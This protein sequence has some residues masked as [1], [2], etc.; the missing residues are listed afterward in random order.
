[1][2]V[3]FHLL[4]ITIFVRWIMVLCGI[5]SA[6]RGLNEACKVY[7]DNCFVK[8][9]I[10]FSFVGGQDTIPPT[11]TSCPPDATAYVGRGVSGTTVSFNVATATDTSGGQVAITYRTSMGVTVNPGSSFSVGRTTVTVTATDPSGNQA[12]CNF[13]VNVNGINVILSLIVCIN[14][15]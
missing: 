6:Q 8:Y 2:H 11:I 7:E 10:L 12:Q 1:M 13:D 4:V 15:K 5:V 3:R 14:C 9:L